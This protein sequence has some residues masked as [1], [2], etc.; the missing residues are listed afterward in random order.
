[1]S[2]SKQKKSIR[3]LALQQWGSRPNF[4]N[5]SDSVVEGSTNATDSLIN[6]GVATNS[7]EGANDNGDGDLKSLVVNNSQEG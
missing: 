1:M 3:P 5:L 4:G 7:S 2:C 6:H